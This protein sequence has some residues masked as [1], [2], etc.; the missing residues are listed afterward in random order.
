[1]LICS[2]EGAKSIAKLDEGAMAGFSPLDPPLVSARAS[3]A[4]AYEAFPIIQNN[5]LKNVLDKFSQ[6]LT[7]L[8]IYY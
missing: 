2:L 1:M 4:W 3:T 6:S 8:V 7:F 5:M